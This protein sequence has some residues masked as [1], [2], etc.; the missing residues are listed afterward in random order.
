MSKVYRSVGIGARMAGV[1]RKTL[2]I[3]AKKSSKG[4]NWL[5]VGSAL[6]D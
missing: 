6:R 5:T 3:K 2:P 4:V 1:D